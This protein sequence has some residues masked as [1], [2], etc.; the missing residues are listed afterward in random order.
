MNK[1]NQGKLATPNFLASGFC[2]KLFHPKTV[3]DE[4]PQYI[5][6]ADA[7]IVSEPQ[8]VSAS[9]VEALAQSSAYQPGDV[10]F[11]VEA[12]YDYANPAAGDFS[13]AVIKWDE[14]HKDKANGTNYKG[15]IERAIAA[16]VPVHGIDLDKKVDSEGEERM[17]HWKDQIDKGTESIKVL[18][19]GAGHMW[20]DPKKTPDLM[21]R[22]GGNQWAIENERAYIPPGYSQV[23]DADISQSVPTERKYKVV[24]YTNPV[25]D[26]K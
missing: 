15:T 16:S 18:L 10:G 11:Y 9:L 24:K 22:L 23:I 4:R 6:V 17:A 19:I 2:I 26:S 13:G 8:D 25:Q 5:L 3:L 7:H 14:H 20:N 1:V 12:L 21:Y